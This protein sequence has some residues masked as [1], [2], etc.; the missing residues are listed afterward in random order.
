VLVGGS[1]GSI[2]A[3]FYFDFLIFLLKSSYSVISAKS[4][5][6]I[7]NIFDTKMQFSFAILLALS[8]LNI[9]SVKKRHFARN[10][11]ENVVC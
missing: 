11:Y 1:I 9:S 4:T 7:I 3:K 10:I 6:R 2:L 5:R 8:Y